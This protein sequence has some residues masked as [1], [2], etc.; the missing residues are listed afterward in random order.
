MSPK[1]ISKPLFNLIP[2]MSPMFVKPMVFTRARKVEYR[3]P[4]WSI[5][6]R[7]PENKGQARRGEEWLFD[8]VPIPLNVAGKVPE[9]T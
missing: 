3:F 6:I 5:G 1:V 4:L 8:H 2:E 9:L 7:S